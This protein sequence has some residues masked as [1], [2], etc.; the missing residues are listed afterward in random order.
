ML[1]RLAALGRCDLP[2]IRFGGRPSGISPRECTPLEAGV[3][4]RPGGHGRGRDR[5][6]PVVVGGGCRRPRRAR[7]F[8]L[9]GRGGRR[10]E[11]VRGRVRRGSGAGRGARSRVRRASR[12]ARGRRR[13]RG[14]WEVRWRNGGI[15]VAAIASSCGRIR[16]DPHARSGAHCLVRR[17]SHR[18]RGG[19]C[20]RGRWKVRWRNG[21]LFLGRVGPLRTARRRRH[22][23]RGRGRR[24]LVLRGGI[25][26]DDGTGRDRPSPIGGGGGRLRRPRGFGLRSGRRRG[27]VRGRIR[28]RRGS[29]RAGRGA[30]CLVR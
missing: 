7:R 15:V 24:L 2:R 25:R 29:G 27:S 8:R 22:G 21:W 17:A 9:G 19:R 18:A 14:R 10:R 23:D 12:R 16:R 28:I 26:R 11:S 20:G 1:V 6:C 30:N 13:G 4:D 3:V 5:H